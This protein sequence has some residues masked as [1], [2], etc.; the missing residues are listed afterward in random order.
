MTH[1][2]TEKEMSAITGG[3]DLGPLPDVVPLIDGAT[4]TMKFIVNLLF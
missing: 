3:I 1:E 4:Q 2:I